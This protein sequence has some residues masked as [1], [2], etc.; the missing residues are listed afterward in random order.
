MRS[1]FG[2]FAPTFFSNEGFLQIGGGAKIYLNE[3]WFISPEA[4][5]G[6]E[7]HL[8]VSIGVGYTFRR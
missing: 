6:W 1:R 3:A 4:R 7:P 2:M 8:R 5:I